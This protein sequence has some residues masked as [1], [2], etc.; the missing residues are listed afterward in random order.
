ML[1]RTTLAGSETR[2]ELTL[3]VARR[4]D[5]VHGEGRERAGTTSYGMVEVMVVVVGVSDARLSRL[6]L[7]KVLFSARRFACST[8]E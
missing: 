5:G 2:W 4:N 3:D 7:Q 8:P 1:V 6:H